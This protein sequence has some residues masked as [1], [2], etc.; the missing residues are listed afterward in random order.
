MDKETKEKIVDFG[1]M[2]FHMILPLAIVMIIF[3]ILLAGV[4]NTASME[5]NIFLAILCIGGS[6]LVV[7][8]SFYMHYIADRYVL[9]KYKRK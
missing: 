4:S 5:W 6:I 3:K 7:L 9:S 2:L 8:L 1:L